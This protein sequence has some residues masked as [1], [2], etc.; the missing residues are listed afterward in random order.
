MQITAFFLRNE[1]IQRYNI[2]KTVHHRPTGFPVHPYPKPKKQK[3]HDKTTSEESVKSCCAKRKISL[4]RLIFRL[5]EIDFPFS[6]RRGNE[7]QGLEKVLSFCP[8]YQEVWGGR[9]DKRCEIPSQ[10]GVFSKTIRKFARI[11]KKDDH[12]KQ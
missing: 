2:L 10:A 11:T 4:K 8:S 12:S 6:A 5:A 3:S 7:W 1:T 9:R